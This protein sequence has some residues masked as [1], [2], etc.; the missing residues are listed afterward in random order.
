MSDPARFAHEGV[1]VCVY[2]CLSACL[3]VCICETYARVYAPVCMRIGLP[4]PLYH[5]WAHL[6]LTACKLKLWPLAKRAASVLFPHF[7]PTTPDRPLWEASPMLAQN[8][9]MEHLETAARPLLRGFTQ[10]SVQQCKI[11]V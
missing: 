10:V 3:S 6:L 2:V 5:C 8:L 9:N 11:V 4:L 7:I 1:C